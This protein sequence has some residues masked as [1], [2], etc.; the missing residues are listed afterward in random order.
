VQAVATWRFTP[1]KKSGHTVVTHARVL[2]EFRL[3]QP[4]PPTNQRYEK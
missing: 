3:E 2:L 4:R 1:P